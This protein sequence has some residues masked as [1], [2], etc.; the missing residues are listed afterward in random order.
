MTASPHVANEDIQ[1]TILPKGHHTAIVVTARRLRFI[2][3]T[4]RLG[5]SVILECA[6]LDQIHIEGKHLG[7]GIPDETVDAIAEQGN[8]E[9][10]L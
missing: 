6:Q 5:R 2:P 1:L 9:R 3:L 4:R 7:S 10:V 8:C